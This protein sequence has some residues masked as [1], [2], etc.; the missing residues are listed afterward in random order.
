MPS[1]F[2]TVAKSSV[3]VQDLRGLGCRSLSHEQGSIL[4]IRSIQ[5]EFRK[6][7]PDRNSRLAERILIDA[8]QRTMHT[9]KGSLLWVL[10]AYG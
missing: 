9:V 2:L 3:G 8:L 7:P 6:T 1:G 5:D 10:R 4:V